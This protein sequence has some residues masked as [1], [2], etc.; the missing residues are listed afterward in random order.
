MDGERCEVYM[1]K[2]AKKGEMPWEAAEGASRGKIYAGSSRAERPTS[3]TLPRLI[4]NYKSR[5]SVVCMT[6]SAGWRE[7]ASRLSAER[8]ERTK[9]KERTQ[10]KLASAREEEIKGEGEGVGG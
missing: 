4:Q 2:E 7:P 10:D 3:F 6:A 9:T 1:E 8:N 5:A